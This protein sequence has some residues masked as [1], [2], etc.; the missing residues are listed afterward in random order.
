MTRLHRLLAAD[1]ARSTSRI[2]TTSRRRRSCSTPGQPSATR[3]LVEP[4]DPRPGHIPGAANLP[5]TT[6]LDA[7]G[8]LAGERRA[9]S[10]RSPTLG[11]SSAGDLVASCGS[12]V[13]ACMLL[14][15][16]EQAGLGSGRLFVPSF[17]GWSSSTRDV[18]TTDRGVRAAR[19][20]LEPPENPGCSGAPVPRPRS[21]PPAAA[22]TPAPVP[23]R[24]RSARSARR[25]R[26]KVACPR[27]SSVIVTISRSP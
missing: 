24:R 19:W 9:A 21:R 14:I 2:S 23:R 7:D 22:P 20:R 11:V 10:R 5:W 17:S 27:T 18:A 16:A 8:K 26:Q 1:D 3:G 13:T 12:G 6:L 4:V 25:A 15:A